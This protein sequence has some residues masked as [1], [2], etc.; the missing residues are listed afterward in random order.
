MTK[1]SEKS[2]G[3]RYEYDGRRDEYCV[4]LHG[5]EIGRVRESNDGW[6]AIG[7]GY[8]V[9]LNGAP[10][11]TRREATE[12]LVE[13]ENARLRAAAAAPRL[14]DRETGRAL[15]LDGSGRIES[16]YRCDCCGAPIPASSTDPESF[17]ISGHG[18]SQSVC[19]E[20]FEMVEKSLRPR[21][22]SRD[23]RID[24]N[25]AVGSLVRVLSDL[26]RK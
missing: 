13:R 15:V 3:I 6:Y 26:G 1:T 8:G 12:I 18:E 22:G 17:S 10:R 24:P 16:T 23:E 21:R 20:C 2:K 19:R 9:R 11:R 5:V 25:D 7:G 14:V 4:R